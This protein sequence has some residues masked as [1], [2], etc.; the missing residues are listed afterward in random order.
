LDAITGATEMI[1]KCDMCGTKIEK[2]RCSCGEWKSKE[3]MAD[4]PFLKAIEAFNELKQL[5]LT[6]DAPHLGYAVV[7][8]RGDY[9]NCK[10]VE[11][12]IYKLKKRPYYE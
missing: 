12:F 9:S 6:A 5:T 4:N 2:G 10:E 1:E 8:F 7:F 11:Q 3:E